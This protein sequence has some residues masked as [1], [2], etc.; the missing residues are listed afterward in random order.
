V[1]IV[2]EA[3]QLSLA[4]SLAASGAATNLILLGDPLQLAQVSKASHPNGSGPSV[5][6]H[7]LGET[8]RCLP[9]GV[10]VAD[11]PHAPRRR[12]FISD[13]IYDLP[14][15][16]PHQLPVQNTGGNPAGGCV[17]A[18]RVPTES[19][20]EAELIQTISD[21]SACGGSTHGAEHL[22]GVDDFGGRSTT[23][24]G[25]LR[26]VLDAST[27]TAGVRVGTVDKFPGKRHLSCSSA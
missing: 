11:A 18:R 8:P 15:H 16:L 26:G 4:D 6:Q 25:L 19:M 2:D 21:L 5:L 14:V 23:T 12:G 10:L 24:V 7:V 20:A 22:L 3:G 27:V 13:H 17:P 1:L 9:T